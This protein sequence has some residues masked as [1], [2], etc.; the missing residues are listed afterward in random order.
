MKLFSLQF[1]VLDSPNRRSL[2]HDGENSW[3]GR[4]G[5]LQA[6]DPDAVFVYEILRWGCICGSW[7][8]KGLNEEEWAP[9][10]NGKQLQRRGGMHTRARGVY[11]GPGRYTPMHSSAHG[12]LT[13]SGS[14]FSRLTFSSH[15]CV[16]GLCTIV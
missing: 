15:I 1:I 6:G 2:Q 12:G 10:G 8:N 3:T 13:R 16:L 11:I 14:M 7:R 5:G 4:G 9:E